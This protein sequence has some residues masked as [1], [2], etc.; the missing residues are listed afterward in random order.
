MPEHK[1]G[2][3]VCPPGVGGTDS[4]LSAPQTWG[5]HHLH[6]DADDLRVLSEL[7]WKMGQQPLL[8]DTGRLPAPRTS[9]ALVAEAPSLSLSRGLRPCDDADLRSLFCLF[10]QEQVAW[11]SPGK[12][13]AS[14][15]GPAGRVLWAAPGDLMQRPLG[16]GLPEQVRSTTAP[17]AGREVGARVLGLTSLHHAWPA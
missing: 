1:G 2:A 16:L 10:G 13:P 3:S 6:G 14:P 8:R 12:C 7:I 15:R 11:N 17:G 9:P 5:C 4:T